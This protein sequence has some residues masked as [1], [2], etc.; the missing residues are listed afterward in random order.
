MHNK[1]RNTQGGFIQIIIFIIVV[2][3]VMKFFN[4]TISDAINYFKTFFAE[5][6]R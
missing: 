6:L 4:I 3:I 5:V 2:L 1:F